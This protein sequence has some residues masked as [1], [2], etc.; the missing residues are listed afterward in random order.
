MFLAIIA[1]L[2]AGGFLIYNNKEEGRLKEL[3]EDIV[4]E[5]EGEM[6]QYSKLNDEGQVVDKD[7]SWLDTDNSTGTKYSKMVDNVAYI[8]ILY[9]PQIS[10]LS[11]PV[12]DSCSNAYLKLGA[13]RYY[14]SIDENKMIIAGHRY[15]SVFGK[16]SSSLQEGDIIYF[17]SLDGIIYKYKLINIE[18]LLPTEVERMKTGEWNLTIFTC[19]NDSKKRATFRFVEC[20]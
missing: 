13:C 11:L 15:K 9:F 6:E 10:N 1:L 16:L 20:D 12:I 7:L 19:T 18:Y 5:L 2:G 8:G 3:N 17:K 4:T 14:G